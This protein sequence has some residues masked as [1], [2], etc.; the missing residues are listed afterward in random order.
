MQTIKI[1]TVVLDSKHINCAVH[2]ICFDEDGDSK[3]LLFIQN[4]FFVFH[5]PNVP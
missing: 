1:Q 5:E 4:L 2:Y 3:K